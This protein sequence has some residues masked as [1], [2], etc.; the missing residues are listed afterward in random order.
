M[1]ERVQVRKV[2]RLERRPVEVELDREYTEVGIRS[3]GRGIFHKEP[4]L[5]LELGNKRVFFIKPGD[6]VISN[7]F[8]WEG[9]I[10]MASEAEA[11]TIGSHRF[12]TFLP[13]DDRI[14]IRW[15]TWFFR[16]EPGLELIRRASPG[17]AGRNR[18]L[19]IDRFE[20][21]E[22]PL[23]PIDEQRH[24]AA[25]LDALAGRMQRLT[26]IFHRA[27]VCTGALAHSVRHEVFDRLEEE[28]WPL[29][30]L[31]D[32]VHIEMGQSPPGIAYNESGEG[33][34]LLNGPTEFGEV[35]PTARQ[36]TTVVTKIAEPGDLLVCVRA[37]TGRMNWADQHYCIGRGLAALRPDRSAIDPTFLRH[38]LLHATP[39]M[40]KAALGSTF[41]NLSAK[42]LAATAIVVPALSRQQE[43]GARLDAIEG[44][45]SRATDLRA[46]ANRMAAALQ[47]AALNEAFGTMG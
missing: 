19:A 44:G 4:V 7:V 30:R 31:S 38:A 20:S 15:A 37:S 11:G 25:H 13:V 14:D 46:K 10:A 8:A 45:A 21:L 1:T 47:P 5:G 18:T 26:G 42:R 9:A 24:V 43:I 39:T 17:S 23:P 28:E 36:W 35:S 22:I 2:L 29:M 41:G 27:T 12:M 16:S 3:F 34:P 32:C 6:L 33:M 40:A